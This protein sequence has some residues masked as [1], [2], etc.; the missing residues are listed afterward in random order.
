MDDARANPV[1]L[2]SVDCI[3]TEQ[4]STGFLSS[5]YTLCI[6]M[7]IHISCEYSLDAIVRL[8]IIVGCSRIVARPDCNI[9]VSFSFLTS[10]RVRDIVIVL[11][12]SKR[13]DTLRTYPKMTTICTNSY[14]SSSLKMFNSCLCISSSCAIFRR[15]TDFVRKL[16]IPL[17]IAC[18]LV[19][20][21]CL[22]FEALSF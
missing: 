8:Y 15:Y 11:T 2:A 13:R 9:I 14:S 19:R 12:Y 5:Y 17:R 1:F 20:R 16:Y 22:L 4:V 18:H 6:R 3:L 7:R 21:S 10:L